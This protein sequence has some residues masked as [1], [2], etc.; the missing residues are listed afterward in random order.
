MATMEQQIEQMHDRLYADEERHISGWG[1]TY[2]DTLAGLIAQGFTEF[3]KA[4]G[5]QHTVARE[6]ADTIRALRAD[7]TLYPDGR[8]RLV[9]EARSKADDQLTALRTQQQSALEFLRTSLTARA[10]PGV[11][12]DR[13]M[14][15][16][17][18]ARMVLDGAPDPIVAMME[19]A[20]RHDEVS[21]LVSS[22]WG[23]SY[24][25]AR[26]VSQAPDAHENIRTIALD[27]NAEHPDP[28]VSTA[29]AAL[30]EMTELQMG[31]ACTVY[32]TDQ[33]VE[34]ATEID[35]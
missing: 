34:S 5:Q 7:D 1:T 4:G 33:A 25:R 24:L 35:V 22:S 2:A 27:A 14:P 8:D 13:E 17:D 30:G 9:R 26:G 31:R 23:E 15:A 20:R 28:Q 18:E 10:L 11:S 16:R 3:R 12:N 21:A 19:L 29:A 6:A 32:L